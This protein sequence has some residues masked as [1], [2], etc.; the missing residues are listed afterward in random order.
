MAKSVVNGRPSA[1][2]ASATSQIH[3]VSSISSAFSES[4]TGGPFENDVT[5]P[6]FFNNFAPGLAMQEKIKMY[7]YSLGVQY[8]RRF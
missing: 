2:S 6:S 1:V 4:K 5:A 3:A 7:E 8:Q